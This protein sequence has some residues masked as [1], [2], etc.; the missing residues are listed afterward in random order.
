MGAAIAFHL[1]RR[2]IRDVLVLERDRLGSG[3]T[4]KNAGGVRLQFST[5]INV[6]LSL[7]SFPEIES[8]GDLTGVDPGLHQVGYLFLVTRER[9]VEAFER[10]LALWARLGVA[11]RR[12]DA[13]GA[14]ALL[15]G[16]NVADV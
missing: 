12:L 14:A 9:D 2:G 1:T 8:F 7:R 6:R 3:S 4:T 10:S 15:P 5:E 13:A 16:L 11:A